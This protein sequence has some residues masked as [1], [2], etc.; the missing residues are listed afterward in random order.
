MFL[1][2]RSFDPSFND[3]FYSLAPSESGL[4]VEVPR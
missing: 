1:R 4:L 3:S 2:P